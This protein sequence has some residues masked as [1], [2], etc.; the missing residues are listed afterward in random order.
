MIATIR[1]RGW[2]WAVVA[3]GACAPGETSATAGEI[4]WS[5]RRDRGVY[6]VPPVLGI[7]NGDNKRRSPGRARISR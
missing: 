7:G 2:R 6:P 4:V 1:W 3:S 5:W